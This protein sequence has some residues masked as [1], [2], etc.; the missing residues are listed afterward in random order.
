MKWHRVFAFLA[1]IAAGQLFAADQP[2]LLVTPK[3][4]W[5]IPVTD[6]IPGAPVP[7][8]F[9]VI[10][11]GF[12]GGGTTPNPPEP[13]KPDDDPIVSQVA[14]LS[15]R[16]ND[17]AEGTAAAALVNSLA[18]MGLTGKDLKDAILLAAPIM[19]TQLK[20]GNRIS[21]WAKAVTD[22]TVDRDKII[23]GILKA[24]NIDPELLGAIHA[25]AVRENRTPEQVKASEGFDITAVFGIIQMIIQLLKS[26]GILT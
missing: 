25:A 13:P 24:W 1:V 9:T 23:S 12:N 4:A 8:N 22:I 3:G 10:V 15:S 19:D 16:L 7:A 26:L 20:S 18:K 11:Q 6:G 14:D 2:I 17:K 5:Q 21:T